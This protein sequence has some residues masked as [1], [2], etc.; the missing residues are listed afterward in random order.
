LNAFFVD[1]GK[2]YNGAAATVITGLSHLEG[3][4]VAILADG[5]VRTS[6]TVSGGQITLDRTASVVHVGLPY[7]G[8]LQTMRPEMGFKDGTWQG[9]V[10][11]ISGATVRVHNSGTF[12]YG[13]DAS[14]LDSALFKTSD[15]AMGTPPALFTGDKEIGYEGS[16]DVD[17]RLMIV[18]D[19]PLPLT[20]CAIIQEVG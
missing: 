5:A 4:T 1:C 8:I 6:Q 16:Y 12:K 20:V 18:Q 19:K 15:V 11:R 17:A 3:E 7:T 10:K 2:T 14:H 9:R 13:R